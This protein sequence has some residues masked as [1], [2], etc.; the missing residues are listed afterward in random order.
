MK[1][2]KLDNTYEIINDDYIIYISREKNPVEKEF[3]HL[4]LH[5]YFIDV[6]EH[7]NKNAYDNEVFDE[8][9]QAVDYIKNNFEIPKTITKQI[10]L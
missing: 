5:L 6:F 8:L 9:C 1:I 4:D 2:K 7:N 10:Q 3:K